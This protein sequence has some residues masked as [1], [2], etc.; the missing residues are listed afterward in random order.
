MNEEEEKLLN[1]LSTVG[2]MPT[3]GTAPAAGGQASSAFGAPTPSTRLFSSD[4]ND[5]ELDALNEVSVAGE[6][7]PEYKPS[8]PTFGEEAF[9]FYR[10]AG[11]GVTETSPFVI[12]MIQGARAGMP[13]LTSPYLPPWIRIGAPVAGGI[14]GGATG[15]IGG[16][17]LSQAIIGGPTT[18]ETMP[19]FES[20]R[21]LGSAIAFSPAAFGLPAATADRIGRFVNAIREGAIKN[22]K[23]YFLGE[24]LYGAGS[25]VGTY[26]A[27]KYRPGDP[28]MRFAAETALGTKF[29]NPLM[30]IPYLTSGGYKR[31]KELAVLATKKGRAEAA[32]RGSVRAQ[33][34]VT[35]RLLKIFEQNGEDVIALSKALDAGLPG[36]P[37]VTYPL[38]GQRGVQFTGPTSA[39]KTGSLTLAQIEAS[40]AALD[41]AFST[42]LQRQGK[43]S[44]AAFSNVINRLTEVG[45][46]EALRVAAEM[47]EAWFTTAVAARLERSNLSAAA[48]I[49]KITKDTPEARQDIGK[50]G[51]DEN[52]KALKGGREAEGF[53]WDLAIR[54][55]LRPA[56]QIRVPVAPSEALI[57]RSYMDWAKGMLPELRRMRSRDIDFNN[58]RQVSRLLKQKVLSISEFIKQTGK[59]ADVDGLLSA[60]DVTSRSYPGLIARNIP[61]NVRGPTGTASW[62][63]VRERLFDAG[64]F[65]NKRDYNQITNDEIADAIARDVSGDKVY[66]L[67]VQ[68]RLAPYMGEREVLDSWLAD[69][70]DPSMTAEQLAARA[71]SLDAQPDRSVRF[72]D[73]SLPAGEATR[74]I[75]R[76]KRLSIENTVRQYLDRASEEGPGLTDLDKLVPSEL[77]RIMKDLGITDAH[78]KRYFEGKNTGYYSKTGLVHQNFL[79]DTKT[80]EKVPPI[81]LLNYRSSLLRLGRKATSAG[82]FDTADFYN[83]MAQAMLDDLSKMDS[84]ALDKAREFSKSLNDVFTRT[85]AGQMLGKQATGAARY[86]LETLVQKAYMGASD[87]TILR[88]R[89]VENAVG[90]M[91]DRLKKAV[92]EA[93]PVVPGMVPPN[94]QKEADML[95]RL[96]QVSTDGVVSIQD[97]NNRVLRLLASEAMFT[98]KN[99]RTRLNVN[100]LNDFISEYK[101]LLDEMNITPDLTNAVQAE[102][103]LRAAI[104]RES[105]LNKS[106]RQQM[107]FSKVLAFESPTDAVANMLSPS[108]PNQMRGFERIARLARRGGYDAVQ[109]LKSSIYDYAFTKASNKD[110]VLDPQTFKNLFF[111]PTYKDKPT[112]ATVLIRQGVMSPDEVKNIRILSDRMI[113]IENAM[114]NKRALEDFLQ[115]ADVMADFVMRSAGSQIGQAAGGTL[116]AAS[117]GSKAVRNIFDK[118]PNMMVRKTFQRA[119]QDPAFMSALLRRNLSERERMAFARSLH[120]YLLASGLTFATNEDAYRDEGQMQQI[121]QRNPPPRQKPP[122]PTTR[123]M[124]GLPSGGGAPP[125]GGGGA[126]PTSQSRMML[127][128]L[129]P[130]DPITGAAAMQAGVPPMPG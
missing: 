28:Y 85:F 93:A 111:K 70:F 96:A 94:V 39:Q 102:N 100:R 75:P 13:Y 60:R 88:M 44:L 118:M 3:S 121:L 123:G 47:R 113:Q 105:A 57:S 91:R 65:P 49:N 16:Q 117:A 31:L 15:L 86:P 112:L 14:L 56:G 127:Q 21:N 116:I 69:G 12:G 125:A 95:K 68:D 2:G 5:A 122:A 58:P 97:A 98:D 129:F 52:L 62:D 22:P 63:A 8:G 76:P 45:S 83:S 43:E 108:N 11:A 18:P 66:T 120:S 84:P 37:S 32:E 48:R 82:D 41:P 1:E 109:G 126:P 124:P 90:F 51:L 6:G 40:L 35:R 26:M 30:A 119:V 55:M 80:L 17:Q 36:A 4:L 72:V 106:V 53:Y 110:G 19:A 128:Q 34:E 73:V 103:L 67:A 81:N 78:V 7:G 23:S 10:G 104:E 79:P 87:T 71:R 89:Q 130:N 42:E 9:D 54:D 64:Y 27:E 101:P 114:E 20:G 61:Q 25:S 38:P 24:T 115:G 99:G 74:V 33:D 46:P 59:I 92:D 77:N 50:I 107:A 29:F